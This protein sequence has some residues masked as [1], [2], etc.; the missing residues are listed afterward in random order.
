MN[1]ETFV[2][3]EIHLLIF[4]K[5]IFTVNIEEALSVGKNNLRKSDMIKLQA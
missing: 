3:Y 5:I 1:F 2:S 4:K